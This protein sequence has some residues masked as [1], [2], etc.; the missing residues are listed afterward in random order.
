MKIYMSQNMCLTHL[1]QP[2]ERQ[3]VNY[4]FPAQPPP[5]CQTS[6]SVQGF[7]SEEVDHL[8]TALTAEAKNPLGNLVHLLSIRDVVETLLW[9]EKAGHLKVSE[10]CEWNSQYVAGALSHTMLYLLCVPE[11]SENVPLHQH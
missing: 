7:S 10:Y 5:I 4:F 3:I 1:R 11:L 6:I 9:T 8:L 2:E